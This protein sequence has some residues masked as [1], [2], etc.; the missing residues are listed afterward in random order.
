MTQGMLIDIFDP[1]YNLLYVMYMQ[2]SNNNNILLIIIWLGY[3]NWVRMW[4]VYPD[5]I[6][7]LFWARKQVLAVFVHSLFYIWLAIKV[8]SKQFMLLWVFSFNP[9]G[10]VKPLQIQRTS[11]ELIFLLHL[12]LDLIFISN[13]ILC[14]VLFHVIL[15][16]PDLL[17]CGSHFRACQPT[18]TASRSPLGVL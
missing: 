6:C 15:D 4:F 8:W 3:W 9:L 16:L 12:T 18:H 1:S 14:V 2:Q 11:T 7:F 13:L 17:L 5:F 10:D